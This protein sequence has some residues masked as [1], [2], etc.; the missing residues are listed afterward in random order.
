MAR[1]GVQNGDTLNRG[2]LRWEQCLQPSGA[3]HHTKMM[4]MAALTVQI[5]I[6]E[7][8]GVLDIHW[9]RNIFPVKHTLCIRGP[10]SV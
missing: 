3:V 1:N 2:A 5:S 10:R 7:C 9:K 6:E 8:F 4:H